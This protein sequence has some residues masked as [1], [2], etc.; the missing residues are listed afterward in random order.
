MNAI[1]YH[2]Y[3]HYA[4]ADYSATNDVSDKFM[5]AKVEKDYLGGDG[6][7]ASQF[8]NEYKS[9]MI[10]GG[11]LNE[12]GEILEFLEKPEILEKYFPNNYADVQSTSVR[13]MLKTSSLATSEQIAATVSSFLVSFNQVINLICE[14]IGVNGLDAYKS[15]VIKEYCEK[16]GV[17]AGSKNFANKIIQDLLTHD[18]M[19]KLKLT[20]GVSANISSSAEEV[21][22]LNSCLRSCLLAVEALE[23]FGVGGKQASTSFGNRKYSTGTS[24]GSHYTGGSAGTLQVLVGKLQGLF[25]NVVGA[26]GE[27]AFKRV[28]EVGW[29]KLHKEIQ[30]LNKS[31]GEDSRTGIN[32][33]IGDGKNF[34]WKVTTTGTDIV[35]NKE[36]ENY[37]VSKPD[38]KVVVTNEKVTITYG[39]SVKRYKANRNGIVQSVS[40]VHGS[41]SFLH[42]LEKYCGGSQST[43]NYVYNVAGGNSGKSAR[44]DKEL[45]NRRGEVTLSE[46]VEKWNEIRDCVVMSNLL[47]YLSGLPNMSSLFLVV[48]KQVYPIQDLLGKITKDN[49]KSGLWYR[50]EKTG[51]RKVFSRKRMYSNNQWIGKKARTGHDIEKAQERSEKTKKSIY[52]LLNTAKLD[53][54]LKDFANLCSK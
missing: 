10:T 39:A 29:E 52:D 3:I 9:Q 8:K 35:K 36:T 5:L 18:G 11:E 20:T 37:T 23:D 40:L 31:I 27:L 12:Y 25:S 4:F 53:V 15:A 42:A 49:I 33:F 17:K 16:R 22:T 1:D 44:S 2:D 34:T 46:L 51:P 7:L 54:T 41:T 50:D 13:Q 32:K 14:E 21:A 30:E 26:G 28:S 48:N 47:Y 38:V 6:K 24:N 45:R 43:L 19:K